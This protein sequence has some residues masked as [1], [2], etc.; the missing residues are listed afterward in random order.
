MIRTDMHVHAY[1]L[2]VHTLL[3]TYTCLT[4]HKYTRRTHTQDSK[5][6][7]VESLHVLVCVQMC[8][9]AEGGMSMHNRTRDMMTSTTPTL[10]EEANHAAEH[11]ATQS[12]HA[13]SHAL[14]LPCQR[15]CRS[16]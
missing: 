9:K 10:A 3:R 14:S 4:K 5:G 7:V 2:R 11:V 12:K 16:A 8:R 15:Y 6:T 1:L 13:L